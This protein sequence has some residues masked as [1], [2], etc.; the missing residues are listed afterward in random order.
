M[1]ATAKEVAEKLENEVFYRLGSPK[2]IASDNRSHF[3][4]NTFRRL[5]KEWS[6]QHVLLSAHHPCPNRAEITDADLVRMI[7]SYLN[8]GYGNW[9]V[10][11]HKFA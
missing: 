2:N 6:I 7:A 8:D 4:N 9:D 11:I 1:T 5:C 10:H 3:V